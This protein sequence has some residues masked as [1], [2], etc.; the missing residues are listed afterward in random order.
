M[1]GNDKIN[2]QRVFERKETTSELVQGLKTEFDVMKSVSNKV[3]VI[4][5]ILNN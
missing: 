4:S 3:D 1:S 5:N 2:S